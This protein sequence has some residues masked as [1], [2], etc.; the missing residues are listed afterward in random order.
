MQL[1]ASLY[2]LQYH[3]HLYRL[4]L[5]EKDKIYVVPYVCEKISRGIAYLRL[6]TFDI[7]MRLDN[8]DVTA[9]CYQAFDSSIMIMVTDAMR[10]TYPN[11][12][13]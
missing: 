6:P 12:W 13:E 8:Y 10:N 7:S 2:S 4:Q 5:P 1:Y 3:R 11:I 9:H